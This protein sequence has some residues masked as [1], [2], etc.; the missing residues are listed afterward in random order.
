MA[1]PEVYSLKSEEEESLP[2]WVLENDSGC[3][4]KIRRI[5]GRPSPEKN[6]GKIVDELIAGTAKS[7]GCRLGQRSFS[8]SLR[9]NPKRHKSS[10]L[11]LSCRKGHTDAAVHLLR[12]YGHLINIHHQEWSKHPSL[13]GI[14]EF[15]S[16][17][18]SRNYEWL[19][20][21]PLHAA[22]ASGSLETV[23]LLLEMGVDINVHTCC[24]LTPLHMAA[25][26]SQPEVV[27]Y[28]LKH[29]ACVDAIDRFGN[30]PLLATLWY[31][32]VNLLSCTRV[33]SEL[34][35]GGANS[36]KRNHQG[37]TLV[38]LAA[39]KGKY[40]QSLLVE[41]F[42]MKPSE[43]CHILED[44]VRDCI[45]PTLLSDLPERLYSEL[46][47]EK[48]ITSRINSLLLRGSLPCVVR[49]D[50]REKWHEALSLR[51]KHQV[52]P[53]LT[54]KKEHGGRTEMA[55]L[56]DLDRV[57]QSQL[58]V[59]YQCL[60]I[61]QRCVVTSNRWT[62]TLLKNIIHVDVPN[63][64]LLLLNYTQCFS[65]IWKQLPLSH[66]LGYAI[67]LFLFSLSFINRHLQ[68]II[69]QESFNFNFL[70]ISILEGLEVF[71]SRRDDCFCQKISLSEDLH[72]CLVRVLKVLL[73]V[74]DHVKS[75]FAHDGSVLEEMEAAREL[76][77]KKFFYVQEP[78]LLHVLLLSSENDHSPLLRSPQYRHAHRFNVQ[79]HRRRTRENIP[80]VCALLEWGG[81][82]SVNVCYNS[83]CRP[84]HK[85]IV[86]S[87]GAPETAVHRCVAVVEA[88]LDAGAHVDAVTPEGKT[89][90]DL[91]T[92]AEV[93]ALLTPSSPEPLAC[94]A[95]RTVVAA[96]IPYQEV[97]FVSPR[98]KAFISLH[99][100]AAPH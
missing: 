67:D 54:P 22:A 98:D 62:L 16:I 12:H 71:F 27:E 72:R 36:L 46:L 31:G 91:C 85:A 26:S 42:C 19:L 35:K 75:T 14:L 21:S 56:A 73:S 6:T 77:M 84:I 50:R 25:A 30:T 57:M 83:G 78:S 8:T 89:A 44:S 33:W 10:L 69:A 68:Q 23:Q 38:H 88:L 81:H 1:S 17:R 76:F 61:Q 60:I 97:E 18:F 7:K 20:V 13:M 29:G 99:D 39:L 79:R 94:L 86:L 47:Q 53:D 92:G 59:D 11:M 64:P 65:F 58:E 49:T 43:L 87:N 55:T 37:H 3:Y 41:P 51:E 28:L 74:F 2:V 4:I 93:K 15:S 9:C 24:Q 48:S 82:K 90:F 34:L 95:S 100:P 96:G 52:Y 80:L 45:P 5:F 40:V 66:P 32:P 70:T 63:Q